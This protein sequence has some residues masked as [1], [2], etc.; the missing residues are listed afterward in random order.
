MDNTQLVN[1][2]YFTLYSVIKYVRE[3]FVGLILLLLAVLIIYIVDYISHINSLIFAMPSPI[4]GMP[5]TANSIPIPKIKKTK[6]SK[7][8]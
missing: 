8:Y 6:K 2:D 1:D 4:P 5:A 7:K 3:N